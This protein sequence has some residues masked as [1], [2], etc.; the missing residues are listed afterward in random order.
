LQLVPQNGDVFDYKPGQFSMIH[1]F[2]DDGVTTWQKKAYSMASDPSN[3]EYLE[4]GIKIHGDFTRKLATLKEKDVVGIEGPYGIFTYSA[5]THTDVVMFAGGIGIT[6]FIS[7][8]RCAI[9]QKLGNKIFLYYFNQTEND[10][11]FKEILDD[12]ALK[13]ANLTV[14]YSVDNAVTEGY[15]ASAKFFSQ[16]FFYVR[17][18]SVY[19]GS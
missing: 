16:T 4:F 11:S 6:P 9:E 3:R 12:E 14:V 19:E 15:C 1:L 13:N 7:M 18:G 2:G 5:Q 8:I 10:I 17:A